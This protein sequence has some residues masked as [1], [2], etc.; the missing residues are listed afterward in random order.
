MSIHAQDSILITAVNKI[1]LLPIYENNAEIKYAF[2]PF[3]ND[4]IAFKLTVT[5]KISGSL[6]HITLLYDH[7]EDD[8]EQ[9]EYADEPSFIIF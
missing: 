7:Q 5:D 3:M 9:V 8:F 6:D 2:D 1:K 4:I